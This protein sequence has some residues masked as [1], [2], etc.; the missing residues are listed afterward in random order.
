ME[1]QAQNEVLGH[2]AFRPHV[3]MGLAF[4]R[5]GNDSASLPRSILPGEAYAWNLRRSRSMATS[6]RRG[7]VETTW[8]GLLFLF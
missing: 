3:L 5:I 8:V 4:G 7:R 6:P 1:N 2:L